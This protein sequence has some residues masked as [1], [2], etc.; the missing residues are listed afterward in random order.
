MKAMVLGAGV[1]SRLEPITNKIPKPLVPIA[2]RPVIDHIISLLD[3]HGFDELVCNTHHLA[4][5]MEQHFQGKSDVSIQLHHESELSGDAGGVRACRAFLQDGTFLVVMGDLLSDVD[6]SALLAEHKEK[7]AIATLAVK[8]V[9]DVTRFGVVVTDRNG[10]ITAFQEKPSRNEA[11]S[12]MIS[13]GIY[14]LEPEIFDH[15]PSD[16]SYGFG[17]QLFPD[18]VKKGLP[19]LAAEMNGFWTDIGTLSDYLQANCDAA[20]GAVK[21]PVLGSK[22][23]Y[24]WVCSDAHVHETCH[25][26]GNAIIGAASK[27]E[28]GV[29]LNGD[30]VIGDKCQIGV[31]SSL[32]DCVILPGA[33]VP[34]HSHLSNCIVTAHEVIE[35]GE[36]SQVA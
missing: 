32:E 25:V 16:G 11:L 3:K 18:L 17:K 26:N 2:N 35:C 4:D 21:L 23:N 27:L 8:A 6:L 33:I 9:E 13:T 36:A 14:I 29:R 31:N 5:C 7:K 22:T 20:S 30:V 28:K 19:V 10:Y 15:I 1:G 34:A 24:G 12:N